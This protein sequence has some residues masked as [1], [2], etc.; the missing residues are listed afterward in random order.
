[1]DRTQFEREI[2]GECETQILNHAK[3]LCELV[4]TH[5]ALEVIADIVRMVGS[6]PP[7]R[8]LH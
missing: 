2:T 6:E 8:S 7:E 4:G 1:M 3:L 5:Q